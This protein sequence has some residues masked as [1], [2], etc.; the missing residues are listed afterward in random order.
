MLSALQVNAMSFMMIS[1]HTTSLFDCL[2]PSLNSISPLP[3]SPTPLQRRQRLCIA[4]ADRCLFVRCAGRGMGHWRLVAS[5]ERIER[6]KRHAAL[7]GKVFAAWSYF[8]PMQRRKRR[9]RETVEARFEAVR[10]AQH[11][12]LVGLW[13]QMTCTKRRLQKSL[14][15]VTR[16]TALCAARRV[17]TCWRSRW[18][19]VLFWREKEMR[20]EAA[21]VA[22]VLELQEREREDLEREKERVLRESHETERLLLDLQN[23]LGEKE[24]EVAE[25][26]QLAEARKLEKMEAQSLLV[27]SRRELEDVKEERERM[28]VVEG[29]I[30]D[31]RD[32]VARVAHER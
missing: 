12:K 23:T 27:L 9:L 20:V 21:R 25:L 14:E 13:R 30:A 4:S 11:R 22:A 15:S 26:E 10:V 6:V 31:E 17:F 18:L 29:A 2:I 32:R 19:S 8:V 16:K 7:L 1:L 28:R 24:M 3:P 5:R